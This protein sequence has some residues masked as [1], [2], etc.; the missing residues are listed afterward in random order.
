V[1]DAAAAEQEVAGLGRDLFLADGERRE[2]ERA[3][4]RQGLGPDE[5]VEAATDLTGAALRANA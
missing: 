2:V 3:L 1:R 4:R 5:A